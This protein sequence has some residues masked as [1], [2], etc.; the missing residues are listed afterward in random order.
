MF[1]FQIGLQRYA[2]EKKKGEE[3]PFFLNEKWKTFWERE[4]LKE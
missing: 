3:E 4:N 2:V 1:Y